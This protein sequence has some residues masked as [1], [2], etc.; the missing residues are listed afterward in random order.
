[1]ELNTDLIEMQMP[2]LEKK[3]V[4]EHVKNND[5]YTNRSRQFARGGPVWH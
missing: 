3:C 1:M 2:S 5:F 4:C